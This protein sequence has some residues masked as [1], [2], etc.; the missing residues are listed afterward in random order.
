NDGEG[1]M[2][3]LEEEDRCWCGNS[4]AAAVYNY[5]SQQTNENDGSYNISIIKNYFGSNYSN[6]GFSGFYYCDSIDC[7]DNPQNPWYM[8]AIN[9]LDNVF[10]NYRSLNSALVLLKQSGLTNVEELR[11]DN[12]YWSS[13]DGKD[14]K[15]YHYYEGAIFQKK[16]LS[17]KNNGYIVRPIRKFKYIESVT[18]GNKYNYQE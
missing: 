7:S 12:L 3:W 10:S 6:K 11:N 1:K 13:T 5:Y 8:P 17:N 15:A 14:S 4:D 2:I 9:E 16:S 18:P